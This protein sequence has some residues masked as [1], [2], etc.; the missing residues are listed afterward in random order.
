MPENHAASRLP[1]ARLREHAF[2]KILS[3]VGARPN[4]IKIA[5][6]LAEMRRHSGIEPVLVHTG[7]HYDPKM[8]DD[9]FS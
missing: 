3:I 5:P 1:S 4:F 6:L 8:S 9:F 2:M 7:Q